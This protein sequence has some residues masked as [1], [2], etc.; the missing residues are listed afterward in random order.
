[1]ASASVPARRENKPNKT[2]REETGAEAGRGEVIIDAGA[3][4]KQGRKGR[5]KRATDEWKPELVAKRDVEKREREI[6]QKPQASETPLAPRSRRVDTVDL[7]EE[8]V[9]ISLSRGSK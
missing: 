3:E 7:E 8:D 1:M 4:A 2:A 9:G 5:N 6:L